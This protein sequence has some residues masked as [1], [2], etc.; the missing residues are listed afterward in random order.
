MPNSDRVKPIQVSTLADRD[1]IAIAEYTEEHWG[2]AQKNKYLGEIR[3]KFKHLRD[4]P[5]LGMER[6]DVCDGQR[7]FMVGSHVI[8]YSE[9]ESH[10]MIDRI[11]HQSMD[12]RRHSGQAT[13]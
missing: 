8:L 13:I 12:P 1:L 10:F 11:L 6:S 3:E 7:S 2:E 9:T 5:G 4:M